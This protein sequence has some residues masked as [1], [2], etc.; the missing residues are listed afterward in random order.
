M[1]N[2]GANIYI[3]GGHKLFQ[4]FL[5][6]HEEEIKEYG[7]TPIYVNSQSRLRNIP[8]KNSLIILLEDCHQIK[9]WN[10]IFPLIRHMSKLKLRDICR[11]KFVNGKFDISEYN[12]LG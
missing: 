7:D 12:L 2:K 6:V 11:A 1:E 8:S 10:N 9:E 4:E 3:V 5:R